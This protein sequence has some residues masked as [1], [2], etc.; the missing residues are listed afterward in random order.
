[1]PRRLGADRAR[2]VDQHE[3]G[4]VERRARIA[5][6]LG[7]PMPTKHRARVAQRAGGGDRHAVSPRWPSR[8]RR[9]RPSPRRSRARPSR[10]ANVVA[11]AAE[12][13][14]A[15]VEVVV[16]LGDPGRR[17]GSEPPGASATASITQPGMTTPPGRGSS[18][19]TIRSTVTSER[20]ARQH[21]LLLHAGD[22]PELHVARRGRPPGRGR[23]RR[24]GR[25]AGTAASCSPVNG[26]V[27]RPR[28]AVCA[29]QVG[30]DVAAHDRERQPR[31]AGRVAVGHPGV[32]VLL[33]LQRP[34]PAVLD[35]VAEAVQRADAR[36]AAVGED[37]LARRSPCRSSGRRA[38]PGSSG[39]GSGRVGPGGSPRGRRRTGSGG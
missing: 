9:S 30:A 19:S 38:G 20:C 8:R 16:A 14:P 5:A 37:E 26:H 10:R 7:R 6:V 34:R 32:R 12:L 15:T 31:G 13:V 28:P 21:R 25:S 33:D 23:S 11:V 27:D 22:P 17:T 35:R 18:S 39:S 3:V 4:V 36:V 2:L 24:R 1:M 29:D